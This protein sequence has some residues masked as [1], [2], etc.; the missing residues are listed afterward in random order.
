MYFLFRREESVKFEPGLPV[1]RACIASLLGMIYKVLL[2]N[3][4]DNLWVSA[5]VDILK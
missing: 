1:V 2:L 5:K 4:S 3:D